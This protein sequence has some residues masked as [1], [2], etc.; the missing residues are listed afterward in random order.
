MRK[1]HLAVAILRFLVAEKGISS[2]FYDFR[3][4]LRQIRDSYNPVSSKTELG[5]LRH[6]FET[7]CIVLDDLGASKPTDWTKDT[8]SHIINQR[9][10]QKKTTIV[11][12]NYLDRDLSEA[13]ADE[14]LQ[15]R[16][17]TRLR[18]RLYEMCLIVEIEGEDFRRENRQAAYQFETSA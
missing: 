13:A 12:S 7:Y 15:E 9:Y 2:R 18:S 3:D 6:I 16:I 8:L 4:L 11:T 14:T 17:G 1:T 10:N 5:I